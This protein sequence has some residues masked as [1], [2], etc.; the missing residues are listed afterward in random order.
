MHVESVCVICLFML[1]FANTCEYIISLMKCCGIS[2][3]YCTSLS[4]VAATQN[5][6]FW[7]MLETW[8][9]GQV[10]VNGGVERKL[11]SL[12]QHSETQRIILPPVIKH[13][14]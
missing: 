13:I 10:R 2:S 1:L 11:I 9:G 8:A 14:L 5:Q 6:R 7:E 3:K 4:P 12:L